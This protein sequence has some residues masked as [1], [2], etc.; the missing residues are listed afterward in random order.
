MV[1]TS[2]A[3][4]PKETAPKVGFF[5]WPDG[6]DMASRMGE[7]AE[8]YGFDLVGVADTP[9]Q[10]LDCWVTATQLT[11]A[12]P[13]IP[14]AICV[15]NFTSRHWTTSAAA[16]ASLAL[17]HRPGFILGMG[18]GHSA[19]RNFGM[20][21][22]TVDEMAEDLN[23]LKRLANGESVPNGTGHAWLNW[24]RESP[25]VFL[26]AS[27]ERSLRLAGEAADGVFINFGLQPENI[28]ESTRQVNIGAQAASASRAPANVW[29]VAGLVCRENGGDA[30]A[31]IGKGLAFGAGYIIGKRDPVKRG[32][33]AELAEPMRELVRTYSTR[34]SQADED[35]VHRLGLY[36]YL[37]KRGAICGDPEECLEQIRAAARAGAQKLMLSVGPF[38]QAFKTVELIGR[39][40]LPALRSDGKIPSHA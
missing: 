23:R 24:A 12:A 31:A 6:P 21:G 36:E 22:A 35:L 8:T 38:S 28:A 39:H 40:V 20:D 3:T 7:L 37:L 34:P 10:A 26:A 11:A 2:A 13:S 30:R 5:F 29:Q 18:S 9:G 33:P 19:M 27:H 1:D 25:Q 15:S 14:I 32:V 4:T 16:A 17:I